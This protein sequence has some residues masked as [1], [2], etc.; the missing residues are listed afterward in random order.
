MAVS[1]PENTIQII[2]TYIRGTVSGIK[3]IQATING[4]STG[5]YCSFNR[6]YIPAGGK[7]FNAVVHPAKLCHLPVQ[8]QKNDAV[9]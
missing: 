1:K 2:E 5:K 9:A 8:K 7:K 6:V 4:I 3:F